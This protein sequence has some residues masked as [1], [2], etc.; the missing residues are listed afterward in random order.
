MSPLLKR[1]SPPDLLG[2]ELPDDSGGGAGANRLP[3]GASAEALQKVRSLPGFA[4]SVVL[5]HLQPRGDVCEYKMRLTI[6]A[7]FDLLRGLSGA[8]F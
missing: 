3:R 2:A 5:V 4:E 7:G 1:K 6:R 8:A